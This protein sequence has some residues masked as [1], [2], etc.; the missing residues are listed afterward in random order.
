MDIV[1]I[2]VDRSDPEK[3]VA[4]TSVDL[5]HCRITMPKRA[6]KKLDYYVY[7]PQALKPL[8]YAIIEREAARHGGSIQVGGISLNEDDLEGLPVNPDDD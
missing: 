7:R 8:I 4:N 3:V 5:I 2:S 6:L 1:V